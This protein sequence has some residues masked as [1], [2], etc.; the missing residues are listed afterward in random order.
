MSFAEP[1]E[2]KPTQTDIK[3]IFDESIQLTSQKT[4]VE[5]I[6][7]QIE[8]ANDTKSVFVD[9][10]QV[11]SAL[12][13][14]ITKTLKFAML[15]WLNRLLGATFGLI[16]STIILGILVFLINLIPFSS[17]FMD[18]AGKSESFFYPLLEM[19]GPELYKHAQDVNPEDLITNDK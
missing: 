15:G 17:T 8:V 6:N 19:I 1:P 14:I 2:P 13:N 18:K 10:A 3:Q 16:K 12:A 5:K 7:T 9:S 11:V 4:K